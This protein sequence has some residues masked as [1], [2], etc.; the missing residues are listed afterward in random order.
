MTIDEMNLAPVADKAAR[1]LQGKHPGIT[2]TSGRRGTHEQARAM[3]SNITGKGG[4]KWIVKT[5]AASAQRDQLQAW[6]D[7][8]P[9]AVTRDAIA[10]GLESLLT[11]M[12]DA[13]RLHISKH[14]A[15]AAFDV[16]PVAA[17]AAIIKADMAALPGVTKFL[18]R[19]GGLVRWHV[20]F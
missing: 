1:I 4:R 18:E 6:I 9:Q 13:E 2:F 14:F 10:A 7:A 11:Q 17:N 12:S 3:A 8:H 16:Q 20:Q 15:G 19:E 5:Y